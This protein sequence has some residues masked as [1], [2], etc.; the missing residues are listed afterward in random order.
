MLS[1]PDLARRRE[2][3]VRL[4]LVALAL[5]GCASNHEVRKVSDRTY[6]VTCRDSLERCLIPVQEICVTHGY[7]VL[8][9]T[10]RRAYSGPMPP[11]GYESVEA[12]ATV[13]CR[14]ATPLFGQDPNKPIVP[15]AS[16]SAKVPAPSPPSSAVPAASPPPPPVPP[17]PPAP[18]VPS[19]PPAPPATPEADVGA[20]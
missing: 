16:A 19:A 17:P 10:E 4:V 15:V 9:A 2:R 8:S 5:L 11:D 3:R 18:T 6:A 13:R 20:P 7:D 1:L 14:Q 12:E